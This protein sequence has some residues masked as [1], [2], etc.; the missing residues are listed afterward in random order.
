MNK[1]E[2][3][4][5]LYHGTPDWDVLCKILEEG[6]RPG[7]NL[8]GGN[9]GEWSN[10]KLFLTTNEQIAKKYGHIIEIN[11][12][13]EKL[14]ELGANFINDGLGDPCVVIESETDDILIHYY[15][16][17][18]PEYAHWMGICEEGCKYCKW[19]TEELEEE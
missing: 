16:L 11:I 17:K 8:V 9:R 10:F 18:S 13:K 12:T 7:K 3:I 14:K 5:K 15:Y 4:I 2:E 6:L 1:E 19:E